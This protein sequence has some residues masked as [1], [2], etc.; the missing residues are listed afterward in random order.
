MKTKVDWPNHIVGFVMIVFSILLAFQLEKC[1]ENGKEARLVQSHLQEIVTETEF[2]R[3][4]L[5]YVLDKIAVDVE[6]LDTLLRLITGEE[7]APKINSLIFELLDVRPP[8]IKKNAY[9][10]FTTSG[11]IRFLNDFEHKSA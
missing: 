8:Y 9:N 2:N 10:S 4:Q 5:G 11:D 1:A 3:K 6:K 7:N